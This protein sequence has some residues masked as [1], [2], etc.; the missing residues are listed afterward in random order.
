MTSIRAR[1]AGWVRV[2][3]AAVAAVTLALGTLLL[4]TAIGSANAQAPPTPGDE[5]Q[6]TVLR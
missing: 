6:P 2:R 3:T 5:T 4:L 1:A